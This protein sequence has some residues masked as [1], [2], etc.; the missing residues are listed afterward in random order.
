MA[1]DAGTYFVL[2]NAVDLSAKGISVG[3]LDQT[4]EERDVTAF[5]A[6]IRNLQQTIEASVEL[7]LVFNQDFAAAS[8]HATINPLF[9]GK[10]EFAV[11]LRPTNAARSTTNPGFTFSARVL[12]YSLLDPVTPGDT[13]KS[14]VTL[15]RTTA[16]TVVTA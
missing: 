13:H 4:R 11:E 10:T 2:I 7:P 15:R 16:V 12:R 8:V 3:A 5:G 6:A 14:S 9:T 1:I